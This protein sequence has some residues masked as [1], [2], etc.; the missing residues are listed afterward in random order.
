MTHID[1]ERRLS[2][3]PRAAIRRHCSRGVLRFSNNGLVEES[4]GRPRSVR[5]TVRVGS[6][7]QPMSRAMLIP[8]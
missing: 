3:A 2:D 5:A 8:G 7:D 4:A 1:M 6:K